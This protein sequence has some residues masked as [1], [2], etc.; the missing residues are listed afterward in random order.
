[1]IDRP[2]K[3][4]RVSHALGP[5]YY[6]ACGRYWIHREFY[7]PRKWFVNERCDDNSWDDAYPADGFDTLRDAKEYV[8]SMLAP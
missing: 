5:N 4:R 7:P 6:T 1:V 3:L 2:I 8:A